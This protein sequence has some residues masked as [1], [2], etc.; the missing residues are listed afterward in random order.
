MLR[1]LFV[2]VAICC[3]LAD[4]RDEKLDLSYWLQKCDHLKITEKGNTGLNSP[5]RVLIKNEYRK[6]MQRQDENHIKYE[7][8]LMVAV[9]KRGMSSMSDIDGSVI[10]LQETL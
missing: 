6:C 9:G 10:G 8:Y 5:L 1:S 7:R 3:M 4:S 2:F